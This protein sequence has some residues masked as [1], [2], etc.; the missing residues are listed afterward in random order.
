MQKFYK[1][2]KTS[3]NYYCYYGIAKD[4]LLSHFCYIGATPINPVLF[5]LFIAS[6]TFL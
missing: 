6:K 2:W 3:R 1:Y 4:G 5:N